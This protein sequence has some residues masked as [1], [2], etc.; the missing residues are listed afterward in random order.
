VAP[1]LDDIPK[2]NEDQVGHRNDDD[3]GGLGLG[4]DGADE[5]DRTQHRDRRDDRT[6]RVRPGCPRIFSL[7]RTQAQSQAP[8]VR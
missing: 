5:A 2:G 4:R 3:D 1:A 6:L 7:L 8:G